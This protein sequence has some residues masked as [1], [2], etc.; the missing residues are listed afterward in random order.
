MKKV[1]S[2]KQVIVRFPFY[3]LIFVL[4]SCST[5]PAA[6]AASFQNDTVPKDLGEPVLLNLN[7]YYILY[8]EPVSPFMSDGRVFVPLYRFAVLLDIEPKFEYGEDVE[9]APLSV[10]LSRDKIE[11]VI[12]NRSVVTVTNTQTGQ[13]T[14][15]SYS[16]TET[17]WRELK[18]NF[19]GIYL[20]L[21]V[22]KDAFGINVR[23]AAETA[24]LYVVSD[25]SYVTNS[26]DK[27]ENTLLYKVQP[28]PVI[29]PT[30]FKLEITNGAT[31][32]EYA[33][34]RITLEIKAPDDYTGK[35]EDIS[36]ALLP[37]Y[38]GC[39]YAYAGDSITRPFICQIGTEKNT[40]VCIENL[41]PEEQFRSPLQY[42][43]SRIGVRIK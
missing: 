39:C 25:Q 17:V 29:R 28:T 27:E 38:E 33:A 24:T 10:L 18:D 22:F 11:V 1:F 3:V 12:T 31:Q 5:P 20:P 35:A 43:F 9:Q 14:T 21:D 16:G 37:F 41:L 4:L 15:P 13:T 8:M 7:G 2:L 42:I 40:F 34:F 23:Y 30:K 19:Y 26:L 32:Y 36:V 6:V